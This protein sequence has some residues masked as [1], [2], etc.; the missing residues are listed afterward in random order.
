MPA[1]GVK[2]V[3][4]AGVL[5]AWR[6][7]FGSGSLDIEGAVVTPPPRRFLVVLVLAILGI[8]LLPNGA[9]ASADGAAPADGA[10]PGPS[11]AFEGEPAPPPVRRRVGVNVWSEAQKKALLEYVDSLIIAGVT[12]MLL[13]GFVVRS[14]FIPSESMVP[15]LEINDMILVDELVYRL[16][17]PARGDIVVFRPPERAH[18]SGKDF[19]KRVV[20]VEGDTVR[21]ENDITY[22][23]GAPVDEPFRNRPRAGDDW[24]APRDFEP[25]TV[26]PGHVFCM[27]D[28]RPHSEDSRV[29]GTVPVENI[30]GKAFV[31]FYPLQRMQMLH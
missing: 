16:Y 12:A 23:N 9:P 13:I 10:T 27:G 20:A 29:W 19:I 8:A 24:P 25:V 3:L 15:T 4:L 11:D 22:V 1:Y 18:S 2:G 17:R 5:I 26:P 28:N 7:Y 6:V 21:V 14:F 31:I 30:I